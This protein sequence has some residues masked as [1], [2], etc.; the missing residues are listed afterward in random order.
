MQRVNGSLLRQLG[1]MHNGNWV[2]TTERPIKYNAPEWEK[3]T[4][5]VILFR[6]ASLEDA[7]D[8]LLGDTF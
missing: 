2:V 4:S 5:T 8:V 7:V 1:Q 3:M 6:G